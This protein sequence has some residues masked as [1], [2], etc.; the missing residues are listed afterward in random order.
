MNQLE[1]DRFRALVNSVN[2]EFSDEP[3]EISDFD[4]DLEHRNSIDSYASRKVLGAMEVKKYVT[5]DDLVNRSAFIVKKFLVKRGLIVM[6][7]RGTDELCHDKQFFS[8]KISKENSKNL[9][10]GL[11]KE[12]S[13]ILK[14]FGFDEAKNYSVEEFVKL[15]N[16]LF[17]FEECKMF[18]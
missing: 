5:F 7:N 3:G 15:I 13:A 14:S 4:G 12:D 8:V 1:L 18:I 11:N 2:K 17:D 9:Y 10:L 16:I 6:Y